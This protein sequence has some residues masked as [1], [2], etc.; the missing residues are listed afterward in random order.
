MSSSKVAIVTGAAG[1]VGR[2]V[3]ENLV[4]SGYAVVADDISLAVNVLRVDGKI[5]PLQAD[6]GLRDSGEAAVRLALDTF[7]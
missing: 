2:A 5:V 7:S 4:A 6:V 1:G 3:V